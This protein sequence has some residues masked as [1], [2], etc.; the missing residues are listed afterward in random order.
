MYC[1]D[2]IGITWFPNKL[3]MVR[4][5]IRF[6]HSFKHDGL[7][8]SSANFNSSGEVIHADGAYD[9]GTRQSQVTAAID[10]TIHF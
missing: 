5:E 1:E 6:E 4:P 10:M 8:S 2:A 3:I 9:N 7:A